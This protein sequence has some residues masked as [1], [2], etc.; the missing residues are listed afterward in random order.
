MKRASG[1]GAFRGSWG[2]EHD[3]VVVVDPPTPEAVPHPFAIVSESIAVPLPLEFAPHE[4]RLHELVWVTGGTMSVRLP[5]RV[6]TVPE[7]YGIWLPAGTRHSGRTTAGAALYD[8]LIEPSRAPEVS[9]SPMVVEVPPLLAALLTHLQRTDL[10]E[11]ER[12]RAEAVVFDLLASAEHQFALR[13]PHADRVAPIVTALLDDPTDRRALAA[14]ADEVGVSERTVARLFRLHTGLSFTQWR[15]AL[16]IHHALALLSEGQSV[17]DVA[18]LSGFA[19]ASTFIAAFKRV[20]GVT[21]GAYV[22]QLGRNRR[23]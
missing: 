5:D 16:L 22:A 1:E 21:P 20:M 10:A 23:G 18:D 11:A 3:A 4:H 2:R 15:Q 12:T 17:Q 8:A 9:P 6:V 7:G 13:V 19:Q 14:W